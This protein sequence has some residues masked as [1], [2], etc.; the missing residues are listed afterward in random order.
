MQCQN[1]ISIMKKLFTEIFTFTLSIKIIFSLQFFHSIATSVATTVANISMSQT[2]SFVKLLSPAAVNL[3]R[4]LLMYQFPLFNTALS[5]H[6][7]F[8]A[9]LFWDRCYMGLPP[10]TMAPP[11]Y[12]RNNDWPIHFHCAVS[13]TS[14]ILTSSVRQKRTQQLLANSVRCASVSVRARARAPH[15]III[16]LGFYC[17][18]PKK[19]YN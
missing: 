14:P 7:L 13:R 18:V 19:R 15:Y 16:S 1:Q 5:H 8:R 17:S 4:S 12:I 2:F 6:C 9:L 3:R 10:A 11:S